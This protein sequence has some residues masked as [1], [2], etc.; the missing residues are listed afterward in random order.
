MG[1]G[2]LHINMSKFYLF[3]ALLPLILVGLK[4]VIGIILGLTKG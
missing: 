1:L 4:I 3:I 2:K